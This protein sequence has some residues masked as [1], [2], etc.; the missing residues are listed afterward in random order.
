M[1]SLLCFTSTPHFYISNA[2]HCLS[3]LLARLLCSIYLLISF[4]V[5]LQNLQMEVNNE[6]PSE[7][8]CKDKSLVL[9]TTVSKEVILHSSTEDMSSFKAY[10]TVGDVKKSQEC[11]LPTPST[12]SQNHQET[13]KEP[14]ETQQASDKTSPC[15]DKLLVLNTTA[16][17]D[18]APQSVTREM[19]INRTDGKVVDEA[20]FDTSLSPMPILSESSTSNQNYQ[21]GAQA[22]G[23]PHSAHDTTTKTEVIPCSRVLLDVYP[24]ELRFCFEPNKLITC[25]LDLTNNTCKKVAFGLLMTSNEKEKS[26]LSRLPI[27]GIVDPGISYTLIVIM[28]K[29]VNLP[30]EREVD[31]ILQTSTYYGILSDVNDVKS[32]KQHFQ[33]AEK[34]ENTVHKM[35]L[36]GVC[37]LPGEMIFERAIPPLVKIISMEGNRSFLEVH[38]IST[39][40]ANQTEPLIIRGS[41]TGHVH[42]WNYDMKKS[43]GSIEIPKGARVWCVKFIERT[44]WFLVGSGDG[45]IH[46]YNYK[47]GIQKI[48][49]I[50]AVGGSYSYVYSLAIHPTESYVLS[51]CHMEIKLF[52]WDHRWFGWKCIQTFKEHTNN[53]RAVAFN[54]EDYDSFASVS[55]DETIK[56]WSLGSPKS[57]YTLSGHLKA[58]NCLDFFTHGDGQQYLITGSA[59]KTA[60]I[61]DMQRKECVHTLPHRSGV[62]SVLPHPKFPLLATGT[63]GGDIYF[64]SSTN[65]RLKRILNISDLPVT[66]LACLN[67]SGRVA[68]AHTNRLSVLEI[69]DEEEQGGVAGND[70]NSIS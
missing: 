70:E 34:L 45:F 58:V 69:R 56:V 30:R 68:V 53:V 11:L 26:F 9:D 2:R 43:M 3:G 67:E 40:D 50:K 33:N 36:K 51:A 27:F 25:S 60:K 31:L 22:F 28:N 64:W 16:S 39:I 63:E 20:K 21:E 13:A 35:T 47:R 32:C 24:L 8:Q 18:L 17:K 14:S 48:T 66:G 37:A 65:F 5:G 12:S 38:N 10:D 44:R 7:M 6:L 4:C 49:S 62:C 23:E 46:V 57:L 42:I 19:F 1:T 61:W 41:S 29:Y 59:D 54:P 52:D 55:D 15:T